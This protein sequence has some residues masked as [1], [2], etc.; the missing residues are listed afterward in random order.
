MRVSLDVRTKMYLVFFSA[1]AMFAFFSDVL[2][3]SLI[4]F[5]FGLQLLMGNSKMS[6]KLFVT[7]FIFYGIEFYVL[8]YCSGILLMLLGTFVILFR[9]LFPCMLAG[10]LLLSTT[11]VSE[12]MAGLQRLHMPRAV[13]IPLTVT[14]RYIPAIRE[15]WKDLSD[16][17]KMRKFATGKQLLPEKIMGRIECIYVPMLISAAQISEDLSAAAVTRGIE[18]PQKHTV[19]HKSKMGV[20]DILIYAVTIGIIILAKRGAQS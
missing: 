18:S 11:T 12:M 6:R 20:F 8:P 9:R 7:Y 1:A 15:E 3:V 2:E 4:L 14:L 5:I 16:A 19:M 13:I 10:L 17:M